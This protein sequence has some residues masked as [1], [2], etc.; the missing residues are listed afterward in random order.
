MVGFLPSIDAVYISICRLVVSL[1]ATTPG[2]RRSVRSGKVPR[3]PWHLRAR[4]QLGI[5]KLLILQMLTGFES[6]PRAAKG[7]DRTSIGPSRRAS[8]VRCGPSGAPGCR[9]SSRRSFVVVQ[10]AA[11]PRTADGSR[12]RVAPSHAHRSADVRVVGDSA[13]DGTRRMDSGGWCGTRFARSCTRSTWSRT[14]SPVRGS[15]YRAGGSRG[16][17]QQMSTFAND[18]G[19]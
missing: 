16:Y 3:Q 10:Q 7:M 11:E 1:E 15:G 13:R 4:W 14:P 2:V 12:P 8:V 17:G 5:C 6:H 19:R 18:G 9:R